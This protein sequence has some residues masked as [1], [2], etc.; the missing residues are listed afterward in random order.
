[1]FDNLFDTLGNIAKDSI[2][3]VS[4]PINVAAKVTREVTKPIAKA[5]KDIEKDV[6]G[7]FD[8]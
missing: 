3:I 8:D 6:S 4:A 1:M 2:D 7:F 5:A